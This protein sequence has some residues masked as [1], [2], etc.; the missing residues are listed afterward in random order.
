MDLVQVERVDALLGPDQD[1]LVVGLGVDPGR[2][3]VNLQGT[4]VEHLSK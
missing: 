4:P 1:V 2:R 3:A